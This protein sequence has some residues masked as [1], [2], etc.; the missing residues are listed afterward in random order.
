MERITRK[1]RPEIWQD[2]D[3]NE[4]LAECCGECCEEVE[5]KHSIL[6]QGFK[7]NCP[8]CGHPDHFCSLCTHAEDNPDHD[9]DFEKGE[10]WR[11]RQW[12]E[13]NKTKHYNVRFYLH[14][15]VDFE[16]E[17]K[18]EKEAVEIA[19]NLEYDMDQL[20]DNMVPDNEE[21]VTEIK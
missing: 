12:D 18:D 19:N 5:V 9:C 2:D 7:F 17:A 14:T 15:F 16:V 4:V 20:L 11:D 3:F 6:R 1:F 8:I 21:D 10:C 13:Y